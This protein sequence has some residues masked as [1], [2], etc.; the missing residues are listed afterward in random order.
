[1]LIATEFTILR[2]I[3]A[4]GR[5]SHDVPKKPLRIATLI[6]EKAFI[7]SGHKLIHNKTVF[8]EDFMHDWNWVDGK[9]RYYTRITD[10]GADVLLVYG[11]KEVSYC[12]QCGKE[13]D[14]PASTEPCESCKKSSIDA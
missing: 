5:I 8:L 3:S 12:T 1:M 9:F 10:H 2:G 14:K 11:Q 13:Q 7:E 6:D 4:N